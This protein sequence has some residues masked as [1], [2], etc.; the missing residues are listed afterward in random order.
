MPGTSAWAAHTPLV[1]SGQESL[2]GPFGCDT[3]TM[4]IEG[5]ASETTERGAFAIVTGQQWPSVSVYEVKQVKR[6]A[7]TGDLKITGE[8]T[9]GGSARLKLDGK[10][11]V[12]E[13]DE[14]FSTFKFKMNC[15]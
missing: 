12:L 11:L 13:L 7:V 2:C 3:L 9:S 4:R 10:A 5:G 15:Q 14:G 6:D 8:R 1:C